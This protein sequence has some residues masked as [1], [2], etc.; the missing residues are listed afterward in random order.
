MRQSRGYFEK[1]Y[2][3]ATP[4]WALARNDAIVVYSS[5]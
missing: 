4:V 2:E 3:I 5:P 1:T